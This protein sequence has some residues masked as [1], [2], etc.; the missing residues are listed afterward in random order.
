MYSCK[1]SDY[2]IDHF[3][4]VWSEAD[5]EKLLNFVLK[6][7]IT[8]SSN[9]RL[10]GVPADFWTTICKEF[11]RSPNAC[12]KQTLILLRKNKRT[13]DNNLVTQDDIAKYLQR[14][15]SINLVEFDSFDLSMLQE[16]EEDS[17][18][19]VDEFD[20]E[21]SGF[22]SQ[23]PNALV[24]LQ[25]YEGETCY[26]SSFDQEAMKL[27]C[28]ETLSFDEHDT[29][30]STIVKHE[31]NPS[32]IVPKEPVLRPSPPPIQLDNHDTL[33]LLSDLPP[34]AFRSHWS[35]RL[36]TIEG[37][38]ILTKPPRK[39]INKKLTKRRTKE[40]TASNILSYLQHLSS[41]EPKDNKKDDGLNC[42]HVTMKIDKGRLKPK[43]LLFSDSLMCDETLSEDEIE[44]DASTDATPVKTKMRFK[45]SVGSRFGSI[46]I[47]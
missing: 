38:S 20:K 40:S 25:T 36:P 10:Y 47:D 7:C 44:L 35:Q 37:R 43:C 28:F 29:L 39:A 6:N 24:D 14:L 3:R 21:I 26:L 30:Q 9:D 17:R 45:T 4:T 33:N 34:T 31:S 41:C 23:N 19:I 22:T 27:Q 2:A 1:N 42:V 46:C 18:N 5:K 16:E 13:T 15:D 32:E 12:R 8:L 11:G